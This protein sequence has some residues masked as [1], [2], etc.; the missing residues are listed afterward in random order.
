MHRGQTLLIDADD[1][2][3]ENN[4]YFERVVEA[5]CAL[6]EARGHAREIA[7]DTLHAIERVRTKSDGYGVRNFHA[8]LRLA[9]AEL[10]GEAG[11]EAELRV[12]ADLCSALLREPPTLLEGVGE[13][14][15]ELCGRHRVILFTK[16]DLDDQLGKLQRSGVR[17]YFHQVDVVREKD[18]AT[19]QDALQRHGIRTASAWMVGNSP[20]SDILPAI[21][22]GLGAVFVP[23]PVTWAL[24]IEE[25]P[26]RDTERYLVL[27]R[28]SRLTDYF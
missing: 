17:P 1:T 5:F 27:D 21:E 19:Y 23:H 2:L 25:L 14:L 11:H 4:I 26:P 16:G 20:R 13:T 7:R 12:I 24:E 10:L 18:T 6:V 28:F 15:A 9:Y 22:C 8:S 3:W